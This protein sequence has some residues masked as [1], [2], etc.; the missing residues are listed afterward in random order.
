MFDTPRKTHFRSLPQSA[1]VYIAAIALGISTAISA[2]APESNSYTTFEVTGVAPVQLGYYAS[3]KKDCSLA[4]LPTVRVIEVP[5]SGVL[6][7]RR[8]VVSNIAACPGTK[9]PGQI[10][11]YRARPGASGKDH[12][13]YEVTTFTGQVNVY[14]VTIEIKEPAKPDVGGGKAPQ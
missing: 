3:A 1:T 12:L 2:E 13:I 4:P 14:D 5:K 8:G 7:V 6:T 11:F 9:I 10:A